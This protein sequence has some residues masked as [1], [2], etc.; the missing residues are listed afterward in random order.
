MPNTHMPTGLNPV[1]YVSGAPYNGAVNIYSVPAG[2]ATALGVG[3]PVKLAGTSQ[4]VGDI[5]YTDVIFALAA[6]VVVGVVV[7]VQADNRDSLLYRAAS[8]Q[9]LVMVADDPNLLF[10]V[11]DLQAG[12]LVAA[13][14]GLNV[15]A[16]AAPVVNTFTG[17]SGLMLDS[18]TKATTN[19]LGWKIIGLVNRPDNE[20]GPAGK[21]LV[22]ANRHA[23]ANQI[24]GI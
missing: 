5:T 15:N 21:W 22:K 2:D 19:T 4:T 13:D 7:A 6:D 14:I 12:T 17:R 16:A 18:A 10:E 8:T 11:Q 24:A 23:Y 3:D 1:R 9:R 20:S